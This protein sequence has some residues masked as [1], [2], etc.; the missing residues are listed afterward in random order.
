MKTETIC[1]IPA[2]GGSKEIPKKN[3]VDLAGKPL[4]AYTIETAKQSGVFDHVY[5]STE[6]SEIAQTAKEYGAEIIDRPAKLATDEAGTLSVLQHAVKD[7]DCDIVVL[8]QATSPFTT[9]DDVKKMVE[10]LKESEAD[11]VVSLKEADYSP[12]WMKKI[13]ENGKVSEFMEGGIKNYV[14]R[15]DLPKLYQLTGA[16]YATRKRVLESGN[17]LGE[18]TLSYLIPE[19]RSLDIDTKFDLKVARLLKNADTN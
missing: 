4:I 7:R 18:N 13:D 11:S 6:D 15:Q 10:K 1:I 9:S 16:I 8:M 12:Y 5:V 2:R 14:R 19:E 17:I 3:I